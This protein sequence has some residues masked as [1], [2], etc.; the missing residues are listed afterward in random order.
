MSETTTKRIDAARRAVEQAA[1]SDGRERRTAAAKIETRAA[2]GGGWRFEGHAAVFDSLSEDL[3]MG[4]LG[5]FRETIKRGFFKESIKRDDI[6]ML[7][8]HDSNLVLAR[9]TAGTL[10][11]GEEPR[12][13]KSIVPEMPDT[14]YARDLR[15]SLDRRDI[16]QMSFGFRMGDGSEEEWH[17][18][19]DGNVTRTLW[20]VG[21]TFDV[22]TVTFPAYTQTDAMARSICGIEV[23]DGDELDPERVRS[24]AWKVHRG[25]LIATVDERR[26]LDV[27]L[28]SCSTV[29][30][31]IAERTL[32]AVASEPELLAAING[33]RASVELQDQHD[34][35]A[36]RLAAAQRRLRLREAQAR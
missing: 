4:L 15:I 1:D 16:S 32:L 14:S 11:L 24:I 22:S 18:D 30:P 28:E 29:S 26:H 13:L 20:K 2:D 12:G 36:F 23:F 17:E 33:K 21:E 3:G 10:D 9:N 35:P 19:K 7:H 27:L 34:Q 25:D 5:S 31:W 8:N 6:R